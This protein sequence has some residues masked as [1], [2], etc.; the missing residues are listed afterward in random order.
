MS[1]EGN[2]VATTTIDKRIKEIEVG[3]FILIPFVC[4]IKIEKRNSNKMLFYFILNNTPWSTY[5]SNYI[6]F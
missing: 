5:Y 6:P 2:A 1:I 4:N 3:V